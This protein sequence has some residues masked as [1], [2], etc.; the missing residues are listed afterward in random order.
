MVSTK[1]PIEM[2]HD[3]LIVMSV[4]MMAVIIVY[5]V[6]HH[7]GYLNGNMSPDEAVQAIDALSDLDVSYNNFSDGE[8]SNY[9][10]AFDTFDADNDDYLNRTEFARFWQ[11]ELNHLG[12]FEKMDA[13]KDEIL[14]FGEC[15]TYIDSVHQI[16]EV[17]EAFFEDGCSRNSIGIW[18]GI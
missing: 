10:Q 17:H 5:A 8:Q 16:E 18:D 13:N 3:I 15:V 1:R 6:C 9:I 7:G 14:S 12:L 2:C 11:F 4:V